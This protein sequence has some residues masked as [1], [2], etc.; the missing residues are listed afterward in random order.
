MKIHKRRLVGVISLTLAGLAVSAWH[1]ANGEAVAPK[2]AIKAEASLVRALKVEPKEISDVRAAI[3]EVKPRR[4]SD[5]GFRLSG[6]IVKRWVDA[7]VLVRKGDLL[8]TIEDED[9]KNRVHSAETDVAA[10]QAVLVEAQANERRVGGLFKKRYTSALNYDAAVKSLRSSQAKLQSA[11]IALEMAKDQLGYTELRAEFDGIVTAVGAENGQLVNVG[12]MVVRLAD[13]KARD[14]VF[15]IAE[16][17]FA[18][19]PEGEIPRIAVSLLSN[20]AIKVSGKVREISPVADAVTRTFEVKVALENPPAEMRF[21]SSVAGR[22]DQPADPMV[23]LPGGALFDKDG[24]PAVW[25]VGA[26]SEVSLKPVTVV[27]YEIDRVVISKGLNKG[28][29][30]FTAG[31]NRLHDRQKVRFQEGFAK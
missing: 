17:V 31:V 26:N 27:R 5:L 19:S 25:I 28:D 18:N 1:H 21:G 23:V 2:A 9:Y 4:E 20:P 12:Q 16:S 10:T 13:P 7:G 29:I 3:G 24:E 8:A 14:A 15:S 30:V 6:K 11:K 22:V